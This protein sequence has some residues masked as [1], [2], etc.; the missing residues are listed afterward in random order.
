MKV[1]VPWSS[2]PV[3]VLAIIWSSF[4]HGH[5]VLKDRTML[6]VPV[7]D[8][9]S[10]LQDVYEHEVTVASPDVTDFVFLGSKSGFDPMVLALM[11]RP[12]AESGLWIDLNECDAKA[13]AAFKK[14]VDDHRLKD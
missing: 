4:G 5:G 12:L 2:T 3:P 14:L 1:I 6:T 13:V 7:D 10:G 11:W 8:N 9:Y